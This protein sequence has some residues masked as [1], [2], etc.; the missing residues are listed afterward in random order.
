MEARDMSEASAS[1]LDDSYLN[2]V[3]EAVVRVGL[4]LL[5]TFWCFSILRPFIIPVIWGAILA[6]AVFPAYRGLTAKLAG[7]G[8][9]AA[10]IFVMLGLSVVLV[11]A[12]LF[13]G[14]LIETGQQ[15]AQQEVIDSVHVPPPPVEVKDWPLVGGSLYE[16]WSQ[17]SHSLEP[18][19]DKFAPQLRAAAIWLLGAT[20]G[21]GLAIAQSLLSIIIA[22][23]MLVGA[24][25]GEQAATTLSKR[26]VGA[27]GDRLIQM[28]AQTIRS[29][30]VGIVGVAI[31]Q[32]GLIGVGMLAVGV[33][34]AGVWSL[35]CLILA[36]LQLPPL[37]VVG[38]V[39]VYMFSQVSTPIAVIFM[40]W[41]AAASLSDTFLKPILLGRGVEVPM[42]V[43]FLGAIGGFMTSGFIGLFIG[44]VVLSLGYELARAWVNEQVDT[45]EAAAEGAAE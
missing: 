11:P 28:T 3:M 33:P 7:R 35:L 26:I 36:V 41:E 12:M 44:A 31:I 6:V 19:A 13:T 43:I 1:P 4:V 27:S 38:P 10:V 14:S 45:P 30:A 17:A 34:H 39:I 15:L 9:P 5:L 16:L 24:S 40:I 21:T 32:A 8:K 20:V 2:K 37:L 42:L 25:G 29:V 18:L 22:G 23:V